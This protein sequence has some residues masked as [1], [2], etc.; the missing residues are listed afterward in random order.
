MHVCLC[1][2]VHPQVFKHTLFL[3]V[4]DNNKLPCIYEKNY[5]FQFHKLTLCSV[6]MP[7]L[8]LFHHKQ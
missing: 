7:G 2:C 3:S 1:L 8:K 6:Y 4:F 5:N